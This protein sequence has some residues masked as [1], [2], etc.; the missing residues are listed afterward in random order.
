MT[1]LDTLKQEPVFFFTGTLI[2]PGGQGSAMRVYTN[3]RAY[4]DLG[5][6]VELIQFVD[7][8]NQGKPL[9]LPEGAIHLTQLPRDPR[10]MSRRVKKLAMRL[11]WPQAF[12]LNAMF[13]IRR[14]VVDEV[15]A[16]FEEHPRALFH[17]EYDNFASAI[18]AFPGMRSVWSNHD[19]FSQRVQ[20]VW[21]QRDERR[22]PDRSEA[23]RQRVLGRV[24]QAEDLIARRA[25]L[26][27]NIA[28]H[29]HEEFLRRG[30]RNA[31]LFQMS[32]PDEALVP[33]ARAWKEDGKL[34][35]LHLGSVNGLV[36]YE[37]LSYLIGEVLPQLT[38]EVLEGLELWVVGTLADSFYCN[39]IL[40]IAKPYPQVRFLGFVEDL[41]GMYAQVDVQVVGGVKA[42]GLRTRII[43]SMVYGVPVLST[44]EMAE[45]LSGLVDGENI[46][47]AKDASDFADRL[48]RLV[49]SPPDFDQLARSA[50][51]TYDEHYSREVA[52]EILR[53]SLQQMS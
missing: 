24:R 38:P 35:L 13:P 19:L 51:E 47:L 43:E 30:Y 20:L 12:F 46:L 48:T 44:A 11:G 34:R 33:R 17:F 1:T 41:R 3:L 9:V 23:E 25:S 42:S 8:E 27:L 32:W 18:S 49:T 37:S 15:R 28:A 31:V 7:E 14:Q 36:G 53:N 40:E 2:A 52:A 39:R 5:F 29:E 50:R 10:G 26:I 45:G 21:Q 22:S 16:R 4:L 6:E